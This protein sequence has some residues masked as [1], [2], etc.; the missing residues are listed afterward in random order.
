MNLEI[1]EIK[2]KPTWENFLLECEEKTF[3]QSWYWG[4]F[5]KIMKN[6]IW[7][8]GIYEQEELMAL[9]L[10]IK[11]IA[12]RGTF[13]SVPHGPNI[14]GQGTANK[15]QILNTLLG[16]LKEIAGRE[17][18]DFIRIAPL[19]ERNQENSQIFKELGFKNSPIHIHP[20]L[21]WELDI[22]PTEDELLMQMRKTTRYLIRQSQKNKDIKIF[23]SQ[24]IEDLKIFDHIYQET[25]SRQ[26][27][28]PFSLKYLEAEFLSFYP[29]NQ[30]S[31]FLAKYKNEIISTAIFIFWQDIAFYHHGASSLK[32]P[33]IPASHWLL[34]EAIKEA[35]E[36]NCKKFNFW[37]ISPEDKKNHPWSGLTLFKKGFG[38]Y[39]KEYLKTQDFPL[40]KRYWLISIFEKLR[41][42][43]RGL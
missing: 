42:M 36:R 3:L 10:V 31:I 15:E 17:K 11:E 18:A 8:L 34:W 5:N 16:E 7:R 21:T 35:K 39:E 23:K 29:D 30:T 2:N 28:V 19:W 13:L 33:K 6:R 14:K 38:G 40:T 32:Y 4:E 9:A 1:K 27:F 12:K 43:K 26:H 41:K 22:T 20:E 37:G 24:D 25:V